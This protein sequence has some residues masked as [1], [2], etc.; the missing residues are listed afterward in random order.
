MRKIRTIEEL[1]MKDNFMFGAVM[2]DEEIC[3]E[4]LEMVLRFPIGQ[5][6]V[7]KEKSMVYHPE[8]KSIRLDV[9]AKDENNTHYNVEMQ[10]Q[11]ENC[12]PKRGRYYHSML[13]AELLERGCEYNALPD[14]YV[15][16]VCDFDPFGKRK[17]C[18]TF[19]NCC[20]EDYSLKLQDGSVSIFLST[21]GKNDAEV[22]EELVKF[23]KY[24][25]ATAENSSLDFEDSYVT[26]LQESMRRI[27]ADREIG[28][29]YMF[30]QELLDDERKEGRAEGLAEGLANGLA[31]GLVL[32]LEGFGEVTEELRAEIMSQGDA[33]VLKSWIKLAVQEKNVDAFILKFKK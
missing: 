22:S 19:E 11:K 16:F 21:K 2:C 14:T 23:L 27:K 32:L 4:F 7:C 6:T 28:G 31:N 13:D 1:T 26:K 15:I 9:V 5:V 30:F 12:M 10:V 29:R 18:Y 33:E 8:Y 3:R 17:Y 25:G 20:L 24:V